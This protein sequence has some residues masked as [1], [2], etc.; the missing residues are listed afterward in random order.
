[1]ANLV[2]KEII[3]PPEPG[4]MGAFGVALEI[5]N[6]LKLGFIEQGIFDLNTLINRTFTYGIDFVCA[7]GKEKCDRKCKV[8]IIEIEGRKY[9]FGGACSKYYNQRNEI[10]SNP[11]SHNYVKLR[12]EL[13]FNKY[14]KLPP[15]LN[16]RGKT[17][18][19]SKSFLTNTLYPLYYNFFTKLGFKV[20]LPDSIDPT[21]IEKMTSSF[22]YPVE[23]SHGLFKD[24]LNKNLDYIFMPHITEM[25]HG[26]DHKYKR[27][28]V[29]VQ[30][31]PYYTRS[32]FKE[33]KMPELIQPVIDLSLP[34]SE[35]GKQF[36]NMAKQLG[37]NSKSAEEAFEF[38]YNAYMQ[39]LHEFCETGKQV[40]D[41][42]KKT[43]LSMLWCFSA[44]RIMHLLR[45]LTLTYR[46]NLHQRI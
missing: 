13:V 10:K 42:L 39:M 44:G 5:K 32:V 31:E 33:E 9:P 24:L 25:G 2:N 4:L 34:E 36:I 43:R 37:K 40:L 29:F 19:I 27:L 14:C 6:R 18:G 17:I 26:N 22:C 20:V 11:E 12:Q 45:R 38:A 3:V 35:L 30:G 23:I 21:G 16:A 46:I 7:G 28:C 8:S 15:A 41:K 1:M